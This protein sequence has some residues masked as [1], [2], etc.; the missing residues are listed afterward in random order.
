VA[1]PSRQRTAAK[2]TLR[3]RGK[4]PLRTR[5]SKSSRHRWT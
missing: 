1:A 2:F 5:S 4:R 3:V